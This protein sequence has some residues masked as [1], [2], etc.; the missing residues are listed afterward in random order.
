M[1]Y[2]HGEMQYVMKVQMWR[3]VTL[4]YMWRLSTIYERYHQV[5]VE[6]GDRR[7]INLCPLNASYTFTA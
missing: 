3:I 7:M 5:D 1:Q 6:E 2:Y 4:P